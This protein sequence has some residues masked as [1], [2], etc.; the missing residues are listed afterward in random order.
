MRKLLTLAGSDNGVL[1]LSYESTRLLFDLEAWGI[2]HGNTALCNS[3]IWLDAT[4]ADVLAKC[5]TNFVRSQT[6][7]VA[8]HDSVPIPV[9]E[10]SLVTVVMT[11]L[12]SQTAHT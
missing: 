12:Q 4:K 5:L 6:V 8:L 2:A 1:N 3:S 7:G 10:E 11:P 9:S